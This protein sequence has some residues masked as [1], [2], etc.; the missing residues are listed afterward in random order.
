[1]AIA[2]NPLREGGGFPKGGKR[3]KGTRKLIRTC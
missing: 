2:S 3:E 1:M